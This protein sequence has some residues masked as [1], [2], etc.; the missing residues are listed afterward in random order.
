MFDF[1]LRD[2]KITK[3]KYNRN[4][5]GRGGNCVYMFTHTQANKHADRKGAETY[6][7]VMRI[8]RAPCQRYVLNSQE[9]KKDN[10]NVVNT[11]LWPPK[12]NSELENSKNE[13][14]LECD[15]RRLCVWAGTGHHH[16]CN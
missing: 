6:D 2:L 9:K 15:M 5:D 7:S 1:D 14:F 4:Q 8:T 3:W 10:K 11:K 12:K 13:K 16:V